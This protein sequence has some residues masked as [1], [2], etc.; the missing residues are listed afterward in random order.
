MLTSFIFPAFVSEYTG[1]ETDILN[2]YSDNF[3]ILLQK[4]SHHLGADLTTFNIRH[5]NF[6]DHELNT[7]FISYIF[8]CAV[9]DIYN[10]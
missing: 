9:S 5:N 7:Q 10:K 6:M 1:N 3:E 4:A 8:G 2:Q